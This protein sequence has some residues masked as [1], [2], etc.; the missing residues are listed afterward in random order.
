[1]EE[2]RLTLSPGSMPYRSHPHSIEGCARIL[3]IN[4]ELVPSLLIDLLVLAN[5]SY[6]QSQVK[7]TN[8]RTRKTA[9]RVNAP[10]SWVKGMR[11]QSLSI[12]VCVARAGGCTSLL[13]KPRRMKTQDRADK[14]VIHERYSVAGAWKGETPGV[15][16]DDIYDKV[17]CKRFYP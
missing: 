15:G 7:V 6:I 14:W 9:P 1:M 13:C 11:M 8:A 12:K 2:N 16:H 10:G 17:A 5:V 4:H 3:I